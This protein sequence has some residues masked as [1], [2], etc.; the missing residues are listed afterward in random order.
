MEL[1]IRE[2]IKAQLLEAPLFKEAL[3]EGQA[4]YRKDVE[5][6]MDRLLAERDGRIKELAEEKTSIAAQVEEQE[7]DENR[8]PPHWLV[9]TIREIVAEQLHNP[10]PTSS[11]GGLSPNMEEYNPSAGGHPLRNWVR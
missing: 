2:H 11:G 8:K 9:S 6:R 3:I 4:E 5:E 1:E 7:K 10:Q